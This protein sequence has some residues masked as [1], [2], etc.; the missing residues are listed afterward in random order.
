MSLPPE[1]RNKIYEYGLAD[2]DGHYIVAERRAHRRL[3]T[4]VPLNTF[5]VT[6]PNKHEKWRRRHLL[7][8]HVS[9]EEKEEGW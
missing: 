8:A 4:R 9:E 6:H 3:G 7:F 5:K 2:P 1:L